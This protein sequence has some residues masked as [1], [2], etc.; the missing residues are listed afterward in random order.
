MSYFFE[1]N[2][3]RK[4]ALLWEVAGLT[5]ILIVEMIFTYNRVLYG[6]DFALI[7]LPA[8]GGYR[9]YSGQIPFRDFH[10]PAGLPLFYML[11]GFFY[12][13][14]GFSFK[15]VA[16]Y[17][18]VMGA[19]GTLAVF[20][21]LR[22]N[23]GGVASLIFSGATAMTLFMPRSHPWLD[24]TAILFYILALTAF[25]FAYRFREQLSSVQITTLAILSGLTLTASIFEKHNIGL[26]AFTFTV[27]LWFFVS[28]GK[29]TKLFNRVKG[30]G[31]CLFSTLFTSLLLIVYFESKGNFFSDISQSTGMMPRLLILLPNAAIKEWLLRDWGR[32][33]FVVY[34][35]VVTLLACFSHLLKL[36]PKEIFKERG[37]VSIIISLMAVSYVGHLSSE[38]GGINAFALSGLLLGLLYAMLS[39]FKDI[40]GNIV[41]DHI[42]ISNFCFATGLIALAVFLLWW[43]TYLTDF[44][45]I[46]MLKGASTPG[47]TKVADMPFLIIM[48]SLACMLFTLGFLCRLPDKRFCSDMKNIFLGSR[49]FVIILAL[50]PIIYFEYAGGVCK[51]AI[52]RLLMPFKNISSVQVKFKDIPALNGVYSDKKIV[53]DIQGLVSWLHPKIDADP[54]L[55]NG[56]GIY[57]FPH[58]TSLY[59]ILGVES[60]RNA[61]L[62]LSYK[63]TFNQLDPD[64]EEIINQSP[65]FIVLYNYASP[66]DPL[67]RLSL[68][69]MPKLEKVLLEDYSLAAQFGD[70]LVFQKKYSVG[71]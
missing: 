21:I 20:A 54:T 6:V 22:L 16:L 40:S 66:Y 70:F 27:P 35:T 49:I 69:P 19:V 14:G 28:F 7:S 29:D 18:A 63:L 39:K 60:F 43:I 9:I 56:T 64:T 25:S 24:E 31:I 52:A 42:R 36:K 1:T 3:L 48:L 65:K 17:S 8:E 13:T 55:K 50:S 15:A 41:V 38:S 5:S 33:V 44:A 61:Y 12:I 59:G 26:T 67:K 10:T 2:P 37:I 71:K 11:A 68:M 58:G 47:R 51:T 30:F 46:V 62:W 34:V 23:L 53:G 57:V 4:K 45:D 32:I